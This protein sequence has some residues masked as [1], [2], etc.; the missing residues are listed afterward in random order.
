MGAVWCTVSSH[1]CVVRSCRSGW[2]DGKQI[3][4]AQP[5]ALQLRILCSNALV[6][7]QSTGL[8]K[9]LGELKTIVQVRLFVSAAGCVHGVLVVCCLLASDQH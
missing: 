9:R 1:C 5:E 7:L 3:V 2:R 8:L 4:A 6:C